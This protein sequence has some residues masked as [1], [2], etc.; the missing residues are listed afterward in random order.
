MFESCIAERSFYYLDA[1]NKRR[2]RKKRTRT[3]RGVRVKKRRKEQAWCKDNVGVNSSTDSER[4]HTLNSLVASDS[5][6]RTFPNVRGAAAKYARRTC[7]IDNAR[8]E[9]YERPNGR[10]PLAFSS[11]P[12]I[13]LR[14]AT[15]SRNVARRGDSTR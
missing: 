9:F 10:F 8:L 6:R 15:H 5:L 7:A 11:C 12:A 3:R 4:E 14:A 1:N 2:E 13:N